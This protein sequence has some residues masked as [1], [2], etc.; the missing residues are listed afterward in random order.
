MEPDRRGAPE[1]GI[2][3]VIG[4]VV[5]GVTAKLGIVLL[6][7]GSIAGG[8]PG[9]GVAG[10]AIVR[11]V[12]ARSTDRRPEVPNMLALLSSRV[13]TWLLLAVAVPVAGALARAIAR[14]LEARSGPTRVSR[15]LF[16]AGDLASR[17]RSGKRADISVGGQGEVGR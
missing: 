1:I 11:R 10:R 2:G 16:S 4:S 5:F 12:I 15:A 3:N 6:T 7:G 17:R 9:C 13:R 8:T 14:R